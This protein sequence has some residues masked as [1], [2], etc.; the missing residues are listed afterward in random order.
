MTPQQSAALGYD[1]DKI[2]QNQQQV[3]A[4]TTKAWRAAH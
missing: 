4:T 2:K 1:M 3:I